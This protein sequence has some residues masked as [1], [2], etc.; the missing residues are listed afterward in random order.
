MC[1]SNVRRPH[2]EPTTR[3]THAITAIAFRPIRL[4]AKLENPERISRFRSR[5]TR[6]RRAQRRRYSPQRQVYSPHGVGQRSPVIDRR[7]FYRSILPLYVIDSGK[8][9]PHWPFPLRALTSSRAELRGA[10][11]HLIPGAI[12]SQRELSLALSV[13]SVTRRPPTYVGARDHRPTAFAAP[14]FFVFKDRSLQ[15]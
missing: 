5:P 6:G 2:A 11:G 15:E 9:N 14:R 12:R 1:A 3:Q 10:S 4:T 13:D 7:C 8:F